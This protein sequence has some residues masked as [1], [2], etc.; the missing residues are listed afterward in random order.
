MPGTL[1]VIVISQDDNIKEDWS[2]DFV[3]IH[4]GEMYRFDAS[5]R[6]QELVAARREGASTLAAP[7]FDSSSGPLLAARTRRLAMSMCVAAWPTDLLDQVQAL[8]AERVHH[9]MR[10][11]LAPARLVW[12]ELK[13]T[14][15]TRKFLGNRRR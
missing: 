3:K 8:T 14:P 10:A 2:T 13:T 4:D 12:L 9:V 5:L 1:D 6:E 15:E 7:P 11:R